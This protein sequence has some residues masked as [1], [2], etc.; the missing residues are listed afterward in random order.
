MVIILNDNYE[1]IYDLGVKVQMNLMRLL[2]IIELWKS[3]DLMSG[4]QLPP[5]GKLLGSE[6]GFIERAADG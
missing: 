3:D 4:W 5:L 1:T 2:G 6:L